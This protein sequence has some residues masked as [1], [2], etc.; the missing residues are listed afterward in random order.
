MKN[1]IQYEIENCD[2][3][4]SELSSHISYYKELKSVLEYAH[5][6]IKESSP[7]IYSGCN[8]PYLKPVEIPIVSKPYTT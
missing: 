5:N 7:N 8:L 6:L 2:K 3:K 4:I 1:V